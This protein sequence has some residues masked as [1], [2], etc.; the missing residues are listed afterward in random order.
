METFP[1]LELVAGQ[2]FRDLKDWCRRSPEHEN[3]RPA[4]RKSPYNVPP[5][6]DKR[7][8]F[9]SATRTLLRRPLMLGQVAFRVALPR[10]RSYNEQERLARTRGPARPTD[11]GP[12]FSE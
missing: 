7:L 5:R 6:A 2:G 12:S 11:Q 4:F 3:G 9:S 10:P 8:Q 1:E